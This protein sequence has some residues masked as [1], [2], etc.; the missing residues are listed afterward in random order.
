MPASRRVGLG[1]GSS[2]GGVS[3]IPPRC[4]G[5]KSRP[6][7]PGLSPP[8]SFCSVI[9]SPSRRPARARRDAQT[10]AHA[11]ARRVGQLATRGEQNRQYVLA[12]CRQPAPTPPAVATYARLQ[13]RAGERVGRGGPTSTWGV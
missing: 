9:I 8:V 13:A 2:C 11:F 5:S 3:G 1:G 12:T 6:R 10:A 7:V 4:D